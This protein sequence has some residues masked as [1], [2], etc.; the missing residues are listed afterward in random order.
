MSGV[1]RALVVAGALL[2]LAGVALAA[3]AREPRKA[4]EPAVQARAR[5]IAVKLSDLPGAGWKTAPATPGKASPRCAYYDPDQSKLTEN[6]DYDSPNFTRTDGTYV[7]SSIG[8]FVSARQGRAGYAA[9]VR[10]GLPRCLGQIIAA[11]GPRGSITVKSAG[12]YAFP[13]YGER[14]AAFRVVFTVESGRSAVPAT[15]DIVVIDKG[16]ADAALLFG[17]AGQAVPPNLERQVVGKV[18]ARLERRRPS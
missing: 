8:I 15:I 3:P 16:A 9:V 17:A 1:G 7:S 10:P 14:S 4:I 2:A 18:A 11:S 12:T 6:G 5:Q 13:H